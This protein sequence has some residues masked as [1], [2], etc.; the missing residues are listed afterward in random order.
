MKFFINLSTWPILYPLIR[1]M[2]NLQLNTLYISN[3][4]DLLKIF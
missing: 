3:F 2:L 4:F 1:E